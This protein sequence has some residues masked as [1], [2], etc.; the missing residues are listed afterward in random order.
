[1]RLVIQIGTARP[2]PFLDN[3]LP[4]GAPDEMEGLPLL[5]FFLVFTF[6]KGFQPYLILFMFL[7]RSS[8]VNK[9]ADR[10]RERVCVRKT[11]THRTDKSSPPEAR[12]DSGQTD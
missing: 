5:M 10:R 3:T 1:M 2:S 7:P 8:K 12:K 9:L 6:G 4:S 11:M